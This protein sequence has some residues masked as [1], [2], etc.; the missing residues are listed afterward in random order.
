MNHSN[1]EIETDPKKVMDGINKTLSEL[2]MPERE[3][4]IRDTWR[5]CNGPD[6]DR[7][8]RRYGI[9]S[10]AVAAVEPVSDFSAPIDPRIEI[11]TIHFQLKR[12]SIRIFAIM[13]ED[14]EVG[15]MK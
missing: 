1:T 15:E 13:C 12:K 11:E 8:L 5:R 14:I 4:L 7:H 9:F 10:C 2:M 3:K 6:A